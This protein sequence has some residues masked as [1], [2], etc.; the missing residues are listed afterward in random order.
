[1]IQAVV[2]YHLNPFTCGVARFNSALARQL[3]VP[4]I[5]L[6]SFLADLNWDH[7]LL[8]IKLEEIDSSLKSILFAKLK[9]LDRRYDIFL[10]ASDSS[11]L[12]VAL[13]A[14]ASRVFAASHEILESLALSRQDSV[15]LFAP[16]A[17]VLPEPEPFD[18]TLLTFGMAHKIRSNGYRHLA[19]LL[20][21][22]SRSY[23]LEISTAL[24]EGGAFDESFFTVGQ[25]IS[26]AFRGNVRFLGFLAD[27]EVSIRLRRVDALIA[28][29]P[30][31]VRENN[32][33]VLSGMSHGCPVITNL[34]HKSPRWMTHGQ[35]VFDIASLRKF[36]DKNE[37]RRVGKA[38]ARVAREYSF[39]KLAT[40]LRQQ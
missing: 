16:G 39:E 38:G 14:A 36:P 34:D 15:A 6:K 5:S 18:I 17:P 11:D 27:A 4:L 30:D 1:M 26:D 23:C 37:L 33:S 12:E 28:F 20:E 24:H 3:G 25:E 19:S 7:V 29:F 21:R 31:G 10:H 9:Q 40:F 13:C 22:D 8:S 35:S 32:T 2:S